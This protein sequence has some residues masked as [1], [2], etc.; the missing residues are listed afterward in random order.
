MMEIRTVVEIAI[1][2]LALVG[3][4]LATIWRMVNGR[5]R[6]IDNKIQNLETSLSE[7][8][9]KLG[10]IEKNYIDRFLEMYQRLSQTEA[11]IT[12][13]MDARMMVFDGKID[14]IKDLIHGFASRAML[15]DECR[16]L[17]EASDKL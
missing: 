7:S 17:M 3:A 8:Q 15:K 9:G 13:R 11:N 1:P 14:D 10:S 5:L 6:A 2:L 16:S 12:A 4:L